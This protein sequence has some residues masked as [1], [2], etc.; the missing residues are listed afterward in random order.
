MRKGTLTTRISGDTSLSTNN[1]QTLPVTSSVRRNPSGGVTDKIEPMFGNE[2]GFKNPIN[3]IGVG[4]VALCALFFVV[5]AI[6]N[7]FSLLKELKK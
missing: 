4:V 7:L 2:T 5:E 1:A 3:I 6:I